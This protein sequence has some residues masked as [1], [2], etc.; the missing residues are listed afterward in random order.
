MVKRERYSLNTY[1][2]RSQQEIIDEQD[3]HE[4]LKIKRKAK[5]VIEVKIRVVKVNYAE[6]GDHHKTK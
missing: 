6:D 1:L 3:R 2:I 5:V 4:V